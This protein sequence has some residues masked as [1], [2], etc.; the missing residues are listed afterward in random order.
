MRGI[1]AISYHTAK[2]NVLQREIK[3]KKEQR[4]LGVLTSN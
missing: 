2:G 4:V 3:M 1:A